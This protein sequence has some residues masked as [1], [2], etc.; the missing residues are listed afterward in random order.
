MR[1]SVAALILLPLAACKDEPSTWALDYAGTWVLEVEAVA[2]C[3]SSFRLTFTID[4]DDVQSGDEDSF[5]INST[6]RFT[7]LPSVGGETT[8]SVNRRDEDFALQFHQGVVRTLFQGTAP[9][10]SRLTGFF[11]DDQ[12]I[13]GASPECGADG[14]ATRE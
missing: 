7:S 4:Q 14:V 10:P 5:R 2:N 8:G 12:G 6:W 9:T 3:W 1:S 11:L 13:L